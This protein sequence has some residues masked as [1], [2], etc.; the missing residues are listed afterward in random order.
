[1][2]THI[3]FFALLIALSLPFPGGFG[4]TPTRPLQ[5]GSKPGNVMSELWGV[6]LKAGLNG[7]GIEAV[8]GFGDR[9]NV[10]LGISAL[11]LPYTTVQNMEG[12][13]LQADAI[14]S[15]GGMNFLIDYYPVKNIFHLTAGIV[16]ANNLV[17]VHIK[18]LS[19][20]PYGDITI[21]PEAV[22]TI[23]AKISPGTNLSPYAAIGI[24]NTLPRKHRFSFNFE[25][26]TFYQGA[27]LIQLSGKGVIGPMASEENATKINKIMAQYSWFPMVNFQLTYRI[28]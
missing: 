5:E 12:Y 27:P 26:G 22:G 9:V 18:S 6:G 4:Q 23:T 19:S 3:H 1:M 21:P 24:G 2:K 16:L 10:R 15:L 11:S 8:K 7:I 17:R 14:I 25:I 28:L 20:I 13:N